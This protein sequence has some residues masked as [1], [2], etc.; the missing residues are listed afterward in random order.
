MERS[1]KPFGHIWRFLDN[2]D[3]FENYG[4]TQSLYF[5][6]IFYFEETV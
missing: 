1:V 6:N 2:L 3:Y 5:L 4:R